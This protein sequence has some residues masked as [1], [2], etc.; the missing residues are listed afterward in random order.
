ML[1]VISA[2]SMCMC[3]QLPGIN[4][5]HLTSQAIAERSGAN[6]CS[7]GKG[8]STGASTNIKRVVINNTPEPL[9]K[10]AAGLPKQYATKIMDFIEM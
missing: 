9:W 10:V 3:V 8:K 4:N 1:F 6:H 5:D 7:H 2:L